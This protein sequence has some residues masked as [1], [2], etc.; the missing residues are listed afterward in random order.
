[1]PQFTFDENE[2]KTPIHI[3]TIL[4]QRTFWNKICHPLLYLGNTYLN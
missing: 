3:F 1:M 4:E 2:L